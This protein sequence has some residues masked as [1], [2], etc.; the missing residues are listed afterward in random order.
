MPSTLVVISAVGLL[1]LAL[2]A[3]S[4]P[5]Q[6][7]LACGADPATSMTF[8]WAST[9][10]EDASTVRIW[11]ADGAFNRSFTD[12]S[13][14]SAYTITSKER[15]TYTSPFIH[16][17]RTT[18]LSPETTYTYVV[19]GEGSTS[20]Q[21]RFTT[22]P[23][24]GAMPRANHGN[25]HAL[26]GPLTFGVIGDLGQT[27]DSAS[28]VAHLQMEEDGAWR[29][30]KEGQGHDNNH[31]DPPHHRQRHHRRHHQRHHPY[32]HTS[33]ATYPRGRPLVCRL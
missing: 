17:V 8:S 23:E 33:I 2:A 4:A 13:G 30:K 27:T 28:T 3:G 20:A 1:H 7:H 10:G 18:G 15:E 25:G 6:L 12:E 22:A 24:T 32:H 19:G 11:S 26:G 21:A 29:S 14:G 31:H 16:H 9:S 5:T